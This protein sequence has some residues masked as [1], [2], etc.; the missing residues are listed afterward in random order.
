MFKI[1]IANTVQCCFMS[2]ISA[3]STYQN[4]S[5]FTILCAGDV[6]P[7]MSGPPPGDF[8]G[9][10]SRPQDSNNSSGPS[11]IPSNKPGWYD[12]QHVG[13]WNPNQPVKT[14]VCLCANVHTHTNIQIEYLNLNRFKKQTFNIWMWKN[15]HPRSRGSRTVTHSMTGSGT[16]HGTHCLAQRHCWKLTYMKV[17]ESGVAQWVVHGPM[18]RGHSPRYSWPQFESRI[19]QPFAACHSPSLCPL[20]P[21]SFQLSCPLKA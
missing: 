17:A 13:P 10:A 16:G 8:D 6:K 11:D 5:N 7:P 2:P 20:L 9:A 18:C 3:P 4:V 19:G 14:C 1:K 12:P 21:V 15:T